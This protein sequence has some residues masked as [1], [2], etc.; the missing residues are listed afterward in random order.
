MPGSLDPQQ[1]TLPSGRTPQPWS[2][3]AL[4]DAK[5]PGTGTYWP[6][7]TSVPQQA[8]EP[9]VLIAQVLK[10]PS[11]TAMY[12]PGGE[13]GSWPSPS[14]QQLTLPSCRTPHTRSSLA[15]RDVKGPGGGVVRPSS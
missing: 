13:N 1:A 8:R 10:S 7:V 12:R 5:T 4:I 14:P 2:P 11:L 6:T 15:F 3:P 9:S